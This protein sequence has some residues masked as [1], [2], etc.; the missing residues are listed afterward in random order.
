MANNNITQKQIH[1]IIVIIKVILKF[2]T[3]HNFY[4]TRNTLYVIKLLHVFM[5]FEIKYGIHFD[6][7]FGVRDIKQNNISELTSVINRK[8]RKRINKIN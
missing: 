2:H 6:M 5:S 8:K 1:L 4:T 7:I 3:Y